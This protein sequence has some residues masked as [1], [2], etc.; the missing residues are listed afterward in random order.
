MNP[1]VL[2]ENGSKIPEPARFYVYD[3]LIATCGITK[4]KMALAAVI[5]AIF[6]IMGPLDTKV[7]QCPL[8]LDKWQ[9]LIA[10]PSQ[11]ALGLQF[12]SRTLTVE[13]PAEYRAKVLDF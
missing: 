2:D 5:E 9:E 13:I 7:R 6:A 3:A 4:M 8:A 12:H 10:G 11:L 1:G